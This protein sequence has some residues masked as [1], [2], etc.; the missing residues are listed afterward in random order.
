MIESSLPFQSHFV[1]RTPRAPWQSRRMKWRRGTYRSTN[2][3]KSERVYLTLSLAVQ[4]VQMVETVSDHLVNLDSRK[5]KAWMSNLMWISKL[6]SAVWR[7]GRQPISCSPAFN[8]SFRRGASASKLSRNDRCHKVFH[9]HFGH[10]SALA[11]PKHSKTFIPDTSQC[12][13]LLSHEWWMPCSIFP[14]SIPCTGT[15][16]RG[17]RNLVCVPM[18]NRSFGFST[19]V[20]KNTSNHRRVCCVAINLSETVG[21]VFRSASASASAS[22]PWIPLPALEIL[23]AGPY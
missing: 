10:S 9:E 16:S 2:R 21:V 18:P 15:S 12:F 20:R 14:W 6:A 23:P 17:D 4:V 22:P 7:S 19:T 1:V 11:L 8:F 13:C 5:W 3:A